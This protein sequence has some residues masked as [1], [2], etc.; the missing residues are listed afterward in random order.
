MQH[1]PIHVLS[2]ERRPDALAFLFKTDLAPREL[3]VQCKP[4]RLEALASAATYG[5]GIVGTRTPHLRS[6][7]HVERSL[8]QLAGLVP[9]APWVVVSGLAEGIDACAHEAALERGLATAAVL[10]TGMGHTFPAC[11]GEL[12]RRILES[13]GWILTELEASNT[14][15]ARSYLWR[16]RIIAQTARAVWI[17]E[18]PRRSGAINTANWAARF[19]RDLYVTPGHPED[20]QMA[21][22]ARIL[23]EIAGSF[24]FW[25]VGNLVATWSEAWGFDRRAQRKGAP[26]SPAE[27]ETP[28]LVGLSAPAKAL[29]K[30][31]AARLE[32]GE[33]TH[34]AAL[35]GPEDAE[36]F[37]TSLHEVM[38]VGLVCES[39]GSWGFTWRV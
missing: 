22:N 30:R 18:A 37:F 11:H 3:H 12:R 20:P 10:G 29:L 8:E 14:G 32:A 31:L 4:E 15:S 9:R 16:N 1:F 6:L 35:Q 26:Q 36:T 23:Q 7:L 27:A 5:L 25:D 24:C 39:G 28:S 38:S 21:G 17:V 33:R 34:T 13:G 19:E 2:R